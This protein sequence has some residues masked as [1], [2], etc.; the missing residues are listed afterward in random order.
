MKGNDKLLAALN[1]LLAD[2]LTAINQYAIDDIESLQSQVEQMG[3]AIFLA[4][5][6]EE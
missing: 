1:D 5:Q 4:T 3:L 2:A 6:M